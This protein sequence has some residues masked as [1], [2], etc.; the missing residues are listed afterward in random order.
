MTERDQTE[1]SGPVPEAAAEAAATAGAESRRAPRRLIYGLAALSIFLAGLAAWPIAAPYIS[2]SGRVPPAELG[3]LAARLKALEARPAPAA[4]DLA[5]LTQGLADEAAARAKAVDALAARLSALEGDVKTLPRGDEAPGGDFETLAKRLKAVEGNL[6]ETALDAAELERA[7]TAG[8]T[9]EAAVK[10]L[11]ARL[12]ALEK[13]LGDSREAR[14][15]QGMVLALG[16]LA[17]AV[18]AGRPYADELARFAG[19]AGDHPG[20]EAARQALAAEAARGV[21]TLAELRR[22]FQSLPADIVRA[23]AEPAAEGWLGRAAARL[24]ALVTVRRVGEVAGEATDAIV[25]RAEVRLAEG[26]LKAALA[27]IKALKGAAAETAAGWRR[28]AEA[29]LAAEAALS[30]LQARAVA[31]VGQG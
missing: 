14:R 10:A 5:P 17:L 22:R 8:R 6:A 15:R 18:E 28:A 24:K 31:L 2:P 29:R 11:E 19:L 7:A 26:D 1:A 12:A 3:A 9:A 13:G 16:Q 20:I 21:P 23:G 4:P 25:A 27:E 30:A